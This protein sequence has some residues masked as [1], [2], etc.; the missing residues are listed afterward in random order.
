MR[1]VFIDPSLD[2]EFRTNGYVVIPDFLNQD[3]IQRLQLFYDKQ[4]HGKGVVNGFHATSHINEIEHKKEVSDLI[5]E[6]FNPNSAV[7]LDNYRSLYGAYTVKETDTNSGVRSH[8]DWTFVDEDECASLSIW[9][10]L[11]STD[12]NNGHLWVME[13][14]RS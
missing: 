14:S 9:T 1:K 10:P 11:V 5:A 12:S 3:E 8:M 4:C 6:V 2:E 13:G 7:S